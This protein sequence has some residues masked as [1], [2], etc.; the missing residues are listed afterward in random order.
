VSFQEA[1][2]A[3]AR[4]WIGDGWQDGSTRELKIFDAGGNVG[5]G[6][7]MEGDAKK[8]DGKAKTFP[9]PKDRQ[10]AKRTVDRFEDAAKDALSGFRISDNVGNHAMNGNG[11]LS[12]EQWL[13]T[14]EEERSCYVS[15]MLYIH[16]KLM[17][18]DDRRVIMGSANLNDRSQKGDGDSEIALVVEDQE[19]LQ[20]TM[21]GRPYAASKFAATLRRRL[22]RE[23]LGLMEPQN[24][25]RETRRVTSFMKPAPHPIEDESRLQ[26][27]RAV[28][29]PL[30]DDTILL[31]EGT[32][33]KNREVFTELFRPIPTNLVRSKSA[34]KAYLPD[35]K[36]GHVVPGV[37]LQRVK[38][39]LSEVRGHVV[40]AP[41]D[42]L[43]DD[44][45]FVSGVEW[46]GL[47]PTL[48]IYI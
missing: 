7:Q 13:G 23:H 14:E 16:S 40:E 45:E 26:E 44:K 24:C 9:L 20:T 41:L 35:V 17:I 37:P 29:D 33:R 3:Q 11:H 15:E 47:N 2:V 48:P 43:I 22:Y 12:E 19:T 5:G 27:D 36:N 46:K 31:W 28:A 4:E 34:Y 42:F 18:V 30:A 1:Q 39:R 32:A 21:N 25:D 8:S 6:L 10:E 38:E